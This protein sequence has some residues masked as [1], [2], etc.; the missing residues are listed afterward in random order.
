LKKDL[1]GSVKYLQ[2]FGGNKFK[3]KYMRKELVEYAKTVYLD[4]PLDEIREHVEDMEELRYVFKEAA[5]NGRRTPEV[6]PCSNNDG[7][8]K[9]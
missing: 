6:F 8:E 9:R 5:K 2:G 1:W 4:T 3:E 7:K